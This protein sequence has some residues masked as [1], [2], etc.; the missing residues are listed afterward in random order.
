M[1]FTVTATNHGPANATG[2]VISDPIV[3]GNS[4]IGAIPDT[5]TFNFDPANPSQANWNIGNL[6]ANTSATLLL[7]FQVTSVAPYTNTATLSAILEPDINPVNNTDHADL[8]AAAPGRRSN[9]EDTST[10]RR[11]R[12]AIPSPSP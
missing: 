10:T 11:H 8:H 7:Q 3:P 9:G 4:F 6:T 1:T 2:L 12:S 5:G